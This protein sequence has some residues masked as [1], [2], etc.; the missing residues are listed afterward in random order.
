MQI[1]KPCDKK[2]RHNDV[3][4]KNNGKMRT[5]EKS[6]NLY[7]IRNGLD[8]SY[9]KMQILSNLSNF[10]KSYGHLSDILAFLP[11]VLTK[12]G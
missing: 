12:Y 6:I 8:E 11:Q 9:S 3:I 7:K 5:S 4:T 10:V 2:W 1:W